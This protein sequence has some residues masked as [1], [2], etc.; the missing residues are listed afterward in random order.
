MSIT[1]TNP[2]SRRAYVSS[3]EIA[4]YMGVDVS[5]ITDTLIEQSEQAI[6]DFLGFTEKYIERA[7][8]GMVS[9]ISSLVLSLDTLDGTVYY[10]DYFKNCEIEIVGGTGAGQRKRIA[11]STSSTVTVDGAWSTAPIVGSYYKIV[12]VGQ[13]PRIQDIVIDARTNTIYK[14]IPE[15]IRRACCAQYQ[16]IVQMGS[17]YFTTNSS[18]Y[19]SESIGDYSYSKN[20]TPN[21]LMAPK[22]KTILSSLRRRSGQIVV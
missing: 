10:L 20:K 3:A 17:A 9:A 22:V 7:V 4:E 12:Q 6:D 13:F 11:S 14:L 16:Y 18:E 21:S 15:A 2:T 1:A 19:T 8:T 5:T